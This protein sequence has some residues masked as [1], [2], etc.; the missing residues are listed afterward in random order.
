[1]SVFYAPFGAHFGSLLAKSSFFKVSS[2]AELS[3][4][5]N[6]VSLLSSFICIHSSKQQVLVRYFHNLS[7]PSLVGLLSIFVK[8]WLQ[9]LLILIKKN[10]SSIF[11]LFLLLFFKFNVCLDNRLPFIF[12]MLY[13]VSCYFLST[14]DFFLTA[15]VLMRIFN[16]KRFVRLFNHSLISMEMTYVESCRMM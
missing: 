9:L 8:L 11:L 10:S 16:R 4:F 5:S 12:C 3:S 13:L 6:S 2:S 14:P 7:L 1:M 15:K